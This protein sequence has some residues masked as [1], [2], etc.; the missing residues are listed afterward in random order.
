MLF[1]SIEYLIFLPV[2]LCLFWLAP[3]WSRPLILLVASYYFYM[4]WKASYGLLLAALTLGNFVVALLIDRFAAS[5]KRLIFIAGIA[6]NLGVLALYKYTNFLMECVWAALTNIPATHDS[7]SGPAPLLPIL[8]PLGISFFAFEFIHYLTD[9]YRG[10]KPIANL[11]RF[12]VFAAFFPSQ[13]A[14]PIKRFED[15]DPQLQ[16]LPKPTGDTISDASW[17]IVR[18]LFKKVALGDNLAAIVQTGFAAPSAM[19]TLDSWLCVLAFTWQIYFDFSGYTDIGRGSAL[20]FGFQLPEN[21]NLPYLARNIQ[22]FWHRWHI[23]LSTWL[24]DY[25]FIP[26]GG[27][28]AGRFNTIRNL[29]ITMLL[30]GLWHGAAWHFVLWGALQG[31]ALAITSIWHKFAEKHAALNAVRKSP[32]WDAGAWLGTFVLVMIG[33]VVFRA[34][35]ME[36]ALAVYQGM[37]SWRAGTEPVE[38]VALQFLHSTLP[39]S[40]VVY[41]A[42]WLGIVWMQKRAAQGIVTA[43]ERFDLTWWFRPPLTVRLGFYAVLSF[44]IVGYAS[45]ANMPFIYFQF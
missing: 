35:N 9:V 4:S 21:F 28:R 5:K 39:V 40:L 14:G 12:G 6:L 18:G 1:N 26:L 20:L 38:S 22:D 15:F 36:Q 41:T 37:F 30:G 27:S 13:I 11:V 16:A 45:P 3:K 33:W 19:G 31:V 17:L 2:V 44:L 42:I 25:L 29:M 10:K 24:R 43:P 32:V 34:E 8:L 7:F 23:S